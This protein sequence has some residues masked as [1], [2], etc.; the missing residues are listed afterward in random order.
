MLYIFQEVLERCSSDIPLL[1]PINDMNI[2][3]PGFDK[4][5]EQIEKFEG[6]L[7]AHPLHEKEDID[8]LYIQY[9]EKDKV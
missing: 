4:I 1:D 3:D 9:L 6:R 5:I 2:K 7:F 8:D